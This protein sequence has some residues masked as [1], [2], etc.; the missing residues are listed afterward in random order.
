MHRGH[1]VNKSL[2][3]LDAAKPIIL[4]KFVVS[5]LQQPLAVDIV[6]E[7]FHGKRFAVTLIANKIP[8]LFAAP[9]QW[10]LT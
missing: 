6:L 2:A 4:S 10:V 1:I 8:H 7:E 3:G 9:G 5:Q